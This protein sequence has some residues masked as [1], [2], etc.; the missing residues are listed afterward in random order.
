MD[1]RPLV[2]EFR[3]PACLGKIIQRAKALLAAAPGFFN[4]QKRMID[5]RVVNPHQEP[6]YVEFVK[7]CIVKQPD[8]RLTIGTLFSQ[9]F[10]F[11]KRA[12]QIPLKRQEVKH[13][14]A[15]VIREIYEIGLRHDVLDDRGKQQHGWVG[16]ECRL[17]VSEPVG[18]N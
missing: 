6:A 3:K 7:K 10:Q 14:V 16:I 2:T 18:L 5:G 15:E 11:T 17:D 1:I 13:L 12:G 4:D 8:S 9:Y